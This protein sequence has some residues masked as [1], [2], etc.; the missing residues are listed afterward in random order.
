MNKIIL[1]PQNLAVPILKLSYC[2]N[3]VRVLCDLKV[4]DIT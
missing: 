1:V 4:R 2:R 3:I